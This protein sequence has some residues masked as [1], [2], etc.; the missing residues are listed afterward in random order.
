MYFADI[1]SS[2]EIVFEICAGWGAQLSMPETA[3]EGNRFSGLRI[4]H[5][6]LRFAS[7][8]DADL[9]QNFNRRERNHFASALESNRCARARAT[10]TSEESFA[11]F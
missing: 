2:L 3:E 6:R 8:F 1:A 11:I 10:F 7:L 4:I 5:R 9:G